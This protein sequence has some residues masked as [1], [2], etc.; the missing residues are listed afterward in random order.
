MLRAVG[1]DKDGCQESLRQGFHVF[2][3]V[4]EEGEWILQ[5]KEE[6]PVGD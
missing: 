3:E 2:R 1:K 5:W 4:R 6:S